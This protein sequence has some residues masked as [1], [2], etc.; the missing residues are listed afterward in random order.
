MTPMLTCG[1]CGSNR[2]AFPLR[3]TD[4]CPIACHDCGATLGTFAELRD[5]VAIQIAQASPAAAA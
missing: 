5:Q 3:I 4:N 2:F 1:N